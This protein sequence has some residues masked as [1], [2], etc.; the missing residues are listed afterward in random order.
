MT[1][2]QAFALRSGGVLKSDFE[3]WDLRPRF[4]L[5]DLLRLVGREK[6][7]V[8]LVFLPLFVLGIVLAL[9][10]KPS[11]TANAQV[12][13]RLS[14][15]YVYQ[16]RVGD[17][18]AGAVPKTD[19]VVQAEVAILSS[20]GLKEKV[21]DKLG[22]AA[23]SEVLGKKAAKATVLEREA[24]RQKALKLLTDNLSFETAPEVGVVRLSYK[25]EGA[26][27]SALVLNAI[28]DTYLTFRREVLSDLSSPVLEEQRKA[29]ETRLRQADGA[30]EA[31]LMQ[32]GVGDFVSAKNAYAKMYEN[33]MTEQY[34]A[35]I[36]LSQAKS[37]LTALSGKLTQVPNEIS[38]QRDVDLSLS[39]KLNSLK[40][41]REDLLSRYLP[42][43]Q[44]IRDIDVKISAAQKAISDVGVT[45]KDQRVGLNSIHQDLSLE[46]VRLETETVALTERLS[47]LKGQADQ[48]TRKLQDM[49]AKEAEFNSLTTE[50]DVLAQN[51]KAFT[52]KSQQS[53]AA[54]EIAASGDESVRIV[55]RATPPLKGKSLQKPIMALALLFALFTG[56]CIA[57]V[58]IF[59]RRGFATAN[60]ASLTLDLPLLSEISRKRLA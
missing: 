53:R 52:Q 46:R 38:L 59:L 20:N 45:V 28:A 4:S 26:E 48:L 21:I 17:A 55:S 58:R 30:Y 32:N 22:L 56:I 29:F 51:L 40:A 12:L 35:Q 8:L 49:T 60:S 42:D 31:F 36:N 15:D 2:R 25:G 27:Q 13:V 9:Q 41:E 23:I 44:P 43:S 57:L 14:Q 24:L 50:R 34:Q 37:K 19:E 5:S 39:T 18:G 1:Q 54:N 47:Q 6:L 10:I 33:V 3:G 11:Y 7:L 16:P